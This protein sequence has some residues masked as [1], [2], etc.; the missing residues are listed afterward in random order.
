MLDDHYNAGDV[1]G[2]IDDYYA[3][4][5]TYAPLPGVSL[6]G[7]DLRESIERL[8]ALDAQI[9][10][11]VRRVLVSQDT[12]LVVLDWTIADAGM[13][14]TA[15]D[16]ARRQPDGFWRCI[17]DNSFGGSHGVEIPPPTAAL[18]AG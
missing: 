7:S 12:A 8:V 9:A 13:S 6:T 14:G 11:T 2:L 3:P 4:Q 5:A 18:L 1:Q 10:V 15:T 16:V 17:I